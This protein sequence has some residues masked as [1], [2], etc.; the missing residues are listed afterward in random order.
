MVDPRA[1]LPRELWTLAPL[2]ETELKSTTAPLLHSWLLCFQPTQP[3]LPST[4]DASHLM[5]MDLTTV[6]PTVTWAVPVKPDELGWHLE[7]YKEILPKL[8]ALRLCHRFGK[9][10]NAHITR[11]PPEILGA[12]ETMCFDPNYRAYWNNWSECFEHFEGRCAPI[13]SLTNLAL[14]NGHVEF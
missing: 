3:P 5:D 12:I 13:V 8:I 6:S 7:R 2:P 4:T 9:G 14:P 11:I 1:C 10:P